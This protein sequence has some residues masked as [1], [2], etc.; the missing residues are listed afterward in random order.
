V[1]NREYVVLESHGVATESVVIIH[2]D[3]GFHLLEWI[4]ATLK[5]RGTYI[6]LDPRLPSDRKQVIVNIASG[7]SSI[8]VTEN[9]LARDAGWTKAFTGTVVPHLNAAELII[10][11]SNYI[12]RKV[13]PES[14][15]YMIFTSGSTGMF[16]YHT[17]LIAV[18][19]VIAVID[20]SSLHQASQKAS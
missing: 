6:Y 7:P 1:T 10:P 3:R 20:F 8:L 9:L 5:A 16:A 15:A 12:P 17:I 14:L 11:N 18:I 4:I 2:L 13:E 19:A